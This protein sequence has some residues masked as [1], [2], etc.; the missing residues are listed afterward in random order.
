MG[1]DLLLILSNMSN[2]SHD[3]QNRK[4]TKVVVQQRL[5]G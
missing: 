2:Y 3:K 5:S 1:A 4:I